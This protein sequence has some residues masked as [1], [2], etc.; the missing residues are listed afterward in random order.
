MT[1]RISSALTGYPR[2]T[3]LGELPA[4]DLAAIESAGR[5]AR[6]RSGATLFVEG[7]G[8]GRVLILTEGRVKV[9]ATSATGRSVILGVRGPGDIVGELSAADGNPRIAT[10]TMLDPGEVLMIPG[11]E[12][13]LQLERC[14]GI[15]AALVRILAA[16]LRDADR[17][18]TMFG[19]YDCSTRLAQILVELAETQGK[20]EGPAIL[21][22]IPLTQQDLADWVGASREAVTKALHSFRLAGLIETHRRA[23]V[24]HDLPGLVRRAG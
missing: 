10:A 4:G 13:L 16:R 23:I 1:E 12:F 15:A 3:F 20:P 17:S 21:V 18:R 7:E 11:D 22:D 19:A 8:A 9:F 5:R 24:I 2:G 14:P 6:Q